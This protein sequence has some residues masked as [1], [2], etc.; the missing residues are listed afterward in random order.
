MTNFG[1]GQDP[2]GAPYSRLP[3]GVVGGGILVAIGLIVLVSQFTSG[4]LIAPLMLL[5]IGGVFLMAGI[6]SR[7]TGFLVAAG[8][9]LGV[10]A[11]VA[12]ATID[13]FRQGLSDQQ[14]AA[15]LLFCIA[16]GFMVVIP[17]AAV[18][19]KVRLWWP[20]FPAAVLAII[21]LAL[22]GGPTG[23]KVLV[24]FGYLWPVILIAAGIYLLVVRGG[25]TSG[26][27]RL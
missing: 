15:V 22:L 24:V 5:A 26:T 14:I 2:G 11:G 4:D 27:P 8:I 21:G 25:R 17:L 1:E 13:I 20:V 7:R 10:S 23:L 16:L 6:M 12:A 19:T 9:F 3:E 18:I